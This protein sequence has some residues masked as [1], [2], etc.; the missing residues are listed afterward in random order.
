MKKKADR[1]LLLFNTMVVVV[2]FSLWK[3][4]NKRDNLINK[5]GKYTT[6]IGALLIEKRPIEY[7][8]ASIDP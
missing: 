2:V 6:G 7:Y 3:K 1:D 8:A 5:R 4:K